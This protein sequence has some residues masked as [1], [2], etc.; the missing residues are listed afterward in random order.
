MTDSETP[1]LDA[2]HERNGAERLE[3]IKRWVEYIRDH[4]PEVWGPQ[5]N[6]VVDSQLESARA[7]GHS[8]EHQRRISEI[9]AKVAAE[10]DDRE[11]YDDD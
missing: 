11:R 6:A 10:D 8:A 5:Q 4:P 9:A 2:K 3:G 1:D 7:A